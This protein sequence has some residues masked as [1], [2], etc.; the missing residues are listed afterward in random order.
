MHG[1][2]KFNDTLVNA[3]ISFHKHQIVLPLLSLLLV[4]L[5]D[6]SKLMLNIVKIGAKYT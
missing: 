2:K 1:I 4:S 6:D 3:L 5:P